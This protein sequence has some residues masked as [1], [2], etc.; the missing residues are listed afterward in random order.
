MHDGEVVIREIDELDAGYE[1]EDV[2]VRMLL[3]RMAG[4]PSV[5]KCDRLV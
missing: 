4:R 1:A 5:G 2:A 3:A